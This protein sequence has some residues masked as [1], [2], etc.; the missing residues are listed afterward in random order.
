MWN[1]FKKLPKEG[2]VLERVLNK[3]TKVVKDICRSHWIYRHEAYESIFELFKF[4]ML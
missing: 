2:N 3:H 4:F 1:F